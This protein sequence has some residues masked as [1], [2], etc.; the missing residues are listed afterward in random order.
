M[1]EKR[2]LFDLS[3]LKLCKVRRTTRT[4]DPCGG[5]FHLAKEWKGHLS[6]DPHYPES[7]AAV[8]PKGGHIVWLTDFTGQVAYGSC[9]GMLGLTSS[10]ETLAALFEVTAKLRK[11]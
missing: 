2:K 3:E 7:I 5:G 1:I 8:T 11:E 10:H 4:F 9:L 6:V